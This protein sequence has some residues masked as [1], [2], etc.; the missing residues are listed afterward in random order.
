MSR[1][2]SHSKVRSSCLRPSSPG[3]KRDRRS[4]PPGPISRPSTRKA[5]SSGRYISTTPATNAIPWQ[6]DTCSTAHGPISS[7]G[8]LLVAVAQK[9]RELAATYDSHRQQSTC[10]ISTRCQPPSQ[11]VPATSRG[12]SQ[13]AM[14][15]RHP[16]VI[17]HLHTSLSESAHIITASVLENE[18]WYGTS[19]CVNCSD[20]LPPKELQ[21][22]VEALGMHHPHLP[23]SCYGGNT[24]AMHMSIVSY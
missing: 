5:G 13:Y 1:A 2:M 6:Y 18:T 14:L 21:N 10:P 20:M 19:L 12:I 24:Q 11:H 4:Q 8:L 22:A 3:R 23:W 9:G 16:L 7:G 15:I 17:H